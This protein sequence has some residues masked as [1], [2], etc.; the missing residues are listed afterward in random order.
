MGLTIWETPLQPGIGLVYGLLVGGA[1]AGLFVLAPV[2]WPFWLA[3]YFYLASQ[4]LGRVR[5][6]VAS[7]EQPR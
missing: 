4:L 6:Q 3:G 7:L 5:Q 2:G 1:F